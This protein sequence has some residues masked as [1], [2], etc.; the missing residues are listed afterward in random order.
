MDYAP[1]SAATG[2]MQD[3]GFR[4]HDHIPY[5]IPD[6][7]PGSHPLNQLVLSLVACL[8]VVYNEAGLRSSTWFRMTIKLQHM[9]I[10][11]L[12][13]GCGLYFGRVA[14]DARENAVRQ[15]VYVFV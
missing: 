14:F 3:T 10:S 15:V 12:L 4:M 2:M 5:V 11:Y 13:N 1:T 7:D 6:S 8:G 9:R